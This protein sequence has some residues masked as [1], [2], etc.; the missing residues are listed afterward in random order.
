MISFRSRPK[1]AWAGKKTSQASKDASTPMATPAK[2]SEQREKLLNMKIAQT[3]EYCAQVYNSSLVN[4]SRVSLGCEKAHDVTLACTPFHT[5]LAQNDVETVRTFFKLLDANNALRKFLCTTLVK[6]DKSESKLRKTM[7]E[8]HTN[9]WPE[10][11]RSAGIPPEARH[12]YVSGSI[13]VLQPSLP[14]AMAALS[15]NLELIELLLENGADLQQ[16]DA[17]GNNILHC[18]VLLTH[19]QRRLAY[20]MFRKVLASVASLDDKRALALAENKRGHTPLDLAAQESAPRIVK[21]LLRLD[22][23][24][25]FPLKRCGAYL[26][27]MYD[28]SDYEKCQHKKVRFIVPSHLP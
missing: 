13:S 24:Y 5:A 20:S 17:R 2:C 28:V 27:V 14:I 1:K 6:H 9:S 21:Y 10:C 11:Q 15:G 22:G 4:A 19:E 3:I 16:T 23:V 18:L 12:A 7:E 26:H 8:I 25:R